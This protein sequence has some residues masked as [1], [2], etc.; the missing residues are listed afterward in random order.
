M[1]RSNTPLTLA[2]AP[3]EIRRFSITSESCTTRVG[4]A[5]LCLAL[6]DR[7]DELDRQFAQAESHLLASHKRDSAITLAEMLFEW[8]EKGTLD[9]GPYAVRGVLP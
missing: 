5:H 3:R 6:G 9:P 4:P 2:N 8:S 1:R 7:A